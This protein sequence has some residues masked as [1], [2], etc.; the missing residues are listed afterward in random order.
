M[1]LSPNQLDAYA[2]DGFV[3]ISG[4]I[5]DAS[6]AAAADA[7]WIAMDADPDDRTTWPEGYFQGLDDPAIVACYTADFLA[8]ATA[9]SGHPRDSIGA[10][11]GALAIN[12]FPTAVWPGSHQRIEALAHSDED[13][14][15]YMWALNQD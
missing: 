5:P 8:A 6:A 2:R 3:L 12:I 9:L 13:K 10:P 15:E 11:G 7:M 4:L 1:P 14:Y